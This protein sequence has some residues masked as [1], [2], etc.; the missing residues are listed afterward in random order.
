MHRRLDKGA[1]KVHVRTGGIFRRELYVAAQS[2][3]IGHGLVNLFERLIA[4]NLQLALQM[5]IRTGEE[6]MD[7]RP[8]G[9]LKCAPCAGNIGL[10]GTRQSRDD[11]TLD[12]TSNNAYSF[13]VVLGRDRKA[14]LNHIHAKAI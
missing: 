8:A 5:E 13:I 1:E 14:G 12:F 7:P 10:G 3:G 11:G 2:A 9:V 4:S 6:N